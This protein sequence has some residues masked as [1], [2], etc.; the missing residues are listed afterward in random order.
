[1]ILIADNLTITNRSMKQALDQMDPEPI[2]QLVKQMRSSRS[3]G[4]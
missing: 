1:M 3:R 2:R 4:H